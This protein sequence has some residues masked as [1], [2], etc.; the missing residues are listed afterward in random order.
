[1]AVEENKLDVAMTLVKEVSTYYSTTTL[2]SSKVALYHC[3]TANML[4]SQPNKHI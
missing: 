4:S 3:F 1:M 2:L